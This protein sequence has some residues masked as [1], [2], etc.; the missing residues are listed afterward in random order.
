MKKAVFFALVIL[1]ALLI[2]C[3]TMETSQDNVNS[4]G[5]AL[6]DTNSSD[7][8]VNNLTEFNKVKVGDNISVH[9]LGKL[10]DGSTFDSSVGKSPLTFDVGAGQMIKGFDSG[11]VGMKVG[12][13]KT[14][15][16]PATEAYGE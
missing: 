7:Q 11:V 1:F 3:T 5:N 10:E 15:T 14:I 2:G 4:D 16:I 6:L 12:E 13:A 9:Y 8:G